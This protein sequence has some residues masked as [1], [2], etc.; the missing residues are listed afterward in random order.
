MLNGHYA[1]YG[2]TGNIRR[3][4]AYRYQVVRIWHKSLDRISRVRNRMRE[5]Q[6]DPLRTDHRRSKR[7]VRPERRTGDH[8]WRQ[9]AFAPAGDD[10]SQSPSSQGSLSTRRVICRVTTPI[11]VGR[12][13][14]ERHGHREGKTPVPFR[15]PRPF[16]AQV[17]LKNVEHAGERVEGALGLSRV[18]A[19]W[20]SLSIH[21]SWRATMPRPWMTWRTAISLSLSLSL[22]RKRW[23]EFGA[24]HS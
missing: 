23:N 12:S 16:S 11:F 6:K 4:Q 18:E 1:Y 10:P 13:A 8:I 3:L 24:T 15:R 21:S 9:R 17:I 14:H 19:L 20:A 7:A 2:I 22:R 5:P